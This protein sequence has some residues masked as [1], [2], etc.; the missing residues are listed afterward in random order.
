MS[1]KSNQPTSPVQSK[2]DNNSVPV[3]S[4]PA[5]VFDR[6]CSA[7]YSAGVEDGYRIGKGLGKTGVDDT[8]AHIKAMKYRFSAAG[9]L[10][11]KELELL[12]KK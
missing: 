8:V 3:I 5:D 1:E 12:T 6:V 11:K 9:K 7:L 10:G 4:I 2:A